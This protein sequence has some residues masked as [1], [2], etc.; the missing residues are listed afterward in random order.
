M[1]HVSQNSVYPYGVNGDRDEADTEIIALN[2]SNADHQ[3]VQGD[4]AFFC[5]VPCAI[6][7]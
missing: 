5:L 6:G 3:R 2:G 1:L 7:R 4:S